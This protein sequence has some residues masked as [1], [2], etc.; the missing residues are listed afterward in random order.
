MSAAEEI[1]AVVHDIKL[2]T[3]VICFLTMFFVNSIPMY[4]FGREYFNHDYAIMIFMTVAFTFAWI[5]SSAFPY[6]LIYVK[7]NRDDEDLS[8]KKAGVLAAY[9][10]TA[11][12]CITILIG[13][14]IQLY[15]KYSVDT[16]LWWIFWSRIAYLIT[17]LL[18]FYLPVS[19]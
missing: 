6:V 12:A 19:K 3:A 2:R 10:Y 15:G 18:T 13:T 7:R 14:Y 1:K 8:D 9:T 5:A 17:G 4:L 11:F 16:V